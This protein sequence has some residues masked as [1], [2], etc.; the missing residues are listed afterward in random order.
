MVR[1]CCLVTRVARHRPTEA[2]VHLLTKLRI[3]SRHELH[4]DGGKGTYTI[5]T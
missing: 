4:R 3:Y 5:G 2:L 1:A